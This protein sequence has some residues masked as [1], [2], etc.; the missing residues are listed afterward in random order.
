MGIEEHEAAVGKAFNRMVASKMQNESMEKLFQLM[1]PTVEEALNPLTPCCAEEEVLKRISKSDEREC[2]KVLQ[3]TV[4]RAEDR[5]NHLEEK[6]IAVMTKSYSFF[7]ETIWTDFAVKELSLE[8]FTKLAGS[9]KRAKISSWD[10]SSYSGFYADSDDSDSEHSDSEFGQLSCTS[11]Q[12]DFKAILV[13][14]EREDIDEEKRNLVLA[15]FKT[16][17]R[18]NKALVLQ[19]MKKK[20]ADWEGKEGEEEEEWKRIEDETKRDRALGIPFSSGIPGLYGRRLDNRL[21]AI[22]EVSKLKCEGK[23]DVIMQLLD[24]QRIDNELN[25]MDF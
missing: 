6:A 10:K 22:I 1:D 5:Y 20:I 19:W 8:A 18:K 7:M 3:E 11:M 21:N 23:E 9:A 14:V 13:W 16:S 2:L 24:Q 17:Q 15:V 12:E 25:D 4:S